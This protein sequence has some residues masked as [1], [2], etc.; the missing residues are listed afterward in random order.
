MKAPVLP[1]FLGKDRAGEL[2]PSSLNRQEE[3]M[4]VIKVTVPLE[5]SSQTRLWIGGMLLTRD[6]ML[7]L[8]MPGA[9]WDATQDSSCG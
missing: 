1:G 7:A 6:L 3:E 8:A 5:K 2:Q 4:R 9:G